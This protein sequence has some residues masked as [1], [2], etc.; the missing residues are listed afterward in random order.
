MAGDKVVQGG[1]EAQAE[2]CLKISRAGT[3][4]CSQH[5]GQRAQR[6]NKT[7]HRAFGRPDNRPVW[8]E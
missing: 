7:G 5:R 3:E 1:S 8:L 2:V 6:A 4:M